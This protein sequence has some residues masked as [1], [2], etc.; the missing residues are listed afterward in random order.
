MA[1]A[2]A[3]NGQVIGMAHYATRALAE[4][5]LPR[6]TTFNQALALN[7]AEAAGGAVERRALIARLTGAVKLGLA[8]AE[9]TV[10]AL[11][12]AGLLEERL[13][14]LLALTPA[15]DALVQAYKAG[16]A[17]IAAELYGDL[18]AEDLAAAGRVLTE[19]TAR[20]DAM[21]AAG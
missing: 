7:A 17:G 9:A 20:A 21:L 2:P 16:V 11:T 13:G 8:A 14:D 15:G 6:G 3:V 10:V 1:T 4:R 12:S 5:L 19:V 18:P